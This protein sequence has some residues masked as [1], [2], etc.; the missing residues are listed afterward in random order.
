VA[1]VNLCCS[2]AVPSIWKTFSSASLRIAVGL[3]L[4]GAILLSTE[5]I[6]T[7]LANGY[8]WCFGLL[9]RE[10][11][12][13]PTSF[14]F[15]FLISFPSPIRFYPGLKILLFS[16]SRMCSFSLFIDL[17]PTHVNLSCFELSRRR[18]F[19]S[20]GASLLSSASLILFP[21]SCYYCVFV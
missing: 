20:R 19:Q 7:R 10:H 16:P 14:T 21:P 6:R 4:P 9:F 1:G 12:Y 15:L 11:Y 18:F 8:H 13:R 2:P 17:I 3:A 5:G